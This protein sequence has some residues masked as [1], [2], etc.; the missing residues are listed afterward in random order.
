MKETFQ[1]W[2]AI[3]GVSNTATEKEIKKAHK[4]KAKL[5]HPD[6]QH[7]Q[8]NKVIEENHTM[9]NLCEEAFQIL[10]EPHS[11]MSYDIDWK[12]HQNILQN[13]SKSN[14][15]ARERKI[16]YGYY[17]EPNN[18]QPKADK[19]FID[20]SEIMQLEHELE[21]ARKKEQTIFFQYSGI[22]ARRNQIINLTS[23]EELLMQQV[24]ELCNENPQYI[25]MQKFISKIT[26]K[27]KN[28]PAK[29]FIT[30]QDREKCYAYQ[31]E[32]MKIKCHIKRKLLI[33]NL[34]QQK[35]LLEQEHQKKKELDIEKANILR[36]TNAYE[37][38][39]LYQQYQ[40]SICKKQERREKKSI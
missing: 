20:F 3:L 14:N 13:S 40:N 4:E 30:K 31:E 34:E 7:G 22:C 24:L 19:H 1:D 6:Q 32:Q 39:P 16:F 23:N 5:Y 15:T 28:F 11:R 38:H 26:A 9:F 29:I 18:Y 10:K 25:E 36:L 37:T 8:T 21:I 27:E 33:E 2:Y 17:T 35:T 12:R